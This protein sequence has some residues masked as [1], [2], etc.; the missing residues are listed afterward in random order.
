ME[1]IRV[2]S[3]VQTV[4]EVESDFSDRI[5]PKGNIGMVVECYEHPEGYAVDIPIPD[6]SA[7][8]GFT[9]ENVILTPEQC[10]VLNETQ[11]YHLLFLAYNARILPLP[12]DT[13]KRLQ[14]EKQVTAIHTELS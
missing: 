8:G 1:N 10:V 4:V 6:E 3:K 12:K 2:N 13:G 9:Y 7:V 11:I 14:H 5:I